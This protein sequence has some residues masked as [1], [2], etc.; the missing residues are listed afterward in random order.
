MLLYMV[1]QFL[2]AML[3]GIVGFAVLGEGNYAAAIQPGEAFNEGKA[4]IDELIFTFLLVSTVLN[5]ATST[6]P[7]YQ[8][9]SF[10]ALAIGFSVVAGAIAGGGVSGGAFNPAVQISLHLGNAVDGQEKPFQCIR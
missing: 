5:V 9:N 3:G 8:N 1:A 7:A 4:F 6:A 10:F 2:G